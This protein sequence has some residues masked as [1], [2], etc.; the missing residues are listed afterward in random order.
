MEQKKS[1]YELLKHPK[2]QKKRLEIMDRVGFEC[3]NCG[4]EED[5]LNIHHSYYEKG[6]KPWDY[7]DESLHCLCD[8]CHKKAQDLNT[9]LH[10][11]IGQIEL[12]DI[13]Q[14]YG[15]AVGLMTSNFPMV[16]I[17]VFSYEVAMG[18]GDCWGLKA[19][20]IIDELKDGTIDGYKLLELSK[21][22]KLR[23]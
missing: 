3:E 20:K 9:L 12:A 17:D 10:R 1:Y 13:E 4:T 2:W 22:I 5:T 14:L 18:V 23:L 16:P 19:E 6:L 11:Q 7:P 21:G 8:A 15:Y